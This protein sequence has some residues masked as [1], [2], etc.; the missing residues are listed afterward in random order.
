MKGI[1]FISPYCNTLHSLPYLEPLLDVVEGLLVRDVIDHDD[2]VG[3]P[4]VGGGDGPEPLLTRG[5]P[6]LR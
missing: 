4:V 3:A 2:A 5:V 1:G 6:N